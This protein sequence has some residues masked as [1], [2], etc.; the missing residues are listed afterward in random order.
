M[1]KFR[2]DPNEPEDQLYNRW[3]EYQDARQ[4]E[5]QE[6]ARKAER[7]L[8]D[9]APNHREYCRRREAQQFLLI[10]PDLPLDE[11]TMSDYMKVRARQAAGEDEPELRVGQKSYHE[12]RKDQESK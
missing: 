10:E 7:D 3:N 12:Y 9:S 5:Q 4:K 11:M 1:K 2:I 6:T 8:L